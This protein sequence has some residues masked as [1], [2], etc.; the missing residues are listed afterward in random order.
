M[1]EDLQV[2][3][4]LVYYSK[5]VAWV[6]HVIYYYNQNNQISY[7]KQ[8]KSN[9][10]EYEQVFASNEVLRNFFEDKEKEYYIAI[11]EKSIYDYW[12]CSCL[13][14]KHRNRMLFEECKAAI[15]GEYAEYQYVLGYQNPFKKWFQQQYYLYGTFLRTRSFIWVWVKKVFGKNAT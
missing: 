8:L 10:G 1:C 12:R 15:N 9:L 7:S 14:V 3:P 11:L 13:A 6:D 2:T 5:R 4:R